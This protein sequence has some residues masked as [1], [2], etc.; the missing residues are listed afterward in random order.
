MHKVPITSLSEK[1]IG[2]IISTR[3]VRRIK[4]ADLVGG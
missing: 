1:E 3:V 2:E 4:P